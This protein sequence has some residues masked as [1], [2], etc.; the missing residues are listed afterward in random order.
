MGEKFE[1]E[2]VA[3]VLKASLILNRINRL[4]ESG[5]KLR[6]NPAAPYVLPAALSS[7]SIGCTAFCPCFT[8][9]ASCHFERTTHF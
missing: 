5:D 6:Q 7:S 8:K 2:M 3:V 4:V 9:A 1:L